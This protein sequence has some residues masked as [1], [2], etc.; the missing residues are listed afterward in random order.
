MIAIIDYG[1]GNIA[2]VFNAIKSLNVE[3]ELT[4][5]SKKILEAEKI[6]LPGVGEASFAMKKLKELNLIDT[7][8]NVRQPF[9]GICLGSQLLCSFSEEGNVEC[10]GIIDANVLKIKKDDKLFKDIQDKDEFYF[11][12]SYYIPIIKETLSET[13]N[14]VNFSSSIKKDN[15][16]GV[17]FHP[18]KSSKK[19]LLILKNFL[20]I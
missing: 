20:E 6:I 1:A 11:A 2:S 15:F 19:G 14:I 16:Y 17:Q 3:I 18:E 13:S 7:I 4:N 5:D 12:H 9:L 8:R 10:L